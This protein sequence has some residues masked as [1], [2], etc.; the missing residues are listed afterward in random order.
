MAKSTPPEITTINIA[1]QGDLLLR[2]VSR[3]RGAHY[4]VSSV[5]LESTSSTLS[6]LTEPAKEDGHGVRTFLHS[7]DKRFHHGTLQRLLIYLHQPNGDVVSYDETRS[8]LDFAR[9]V[10]ICKCTNAVKLAAAEILRG[11]GAYDLLRE[12]CG[13]IEAAYRFDNARYFAQFTERLV[14]AD[15]IDILWEVKPNS[16]LQGLYGQSRRHYL[17]ILTAAD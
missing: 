15:H 6:D 7:E 2:F 14:R 13:C 12:S 11:I 8:F 17:Y 10:D 16:P 4:R 5:V 3:D 1:R 9:L